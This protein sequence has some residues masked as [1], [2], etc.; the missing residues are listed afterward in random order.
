[1]VAGASIPID[2]N[3]DYKTP[4]EWL[5][6]QHNIRTGLELA[7][8][9]IPVFPCNED[10][11]PAT[12]HGFKDATT[13]HTRII[14]FFRPRNRVIGMPTGLASN[15]DVIDEDSHRGGDLRQAE[16]IQKKVVARTKSGGRHVFF[17][18]RDG[19]RNTTDLIP[20]IDVRGEGG[21]VILW[22]HSKDGEWFSG[23]LFSDLPEYPDHLRKGGVKLRAGGLDTEAIRNGVK[24]G[25]RNDSIFKGLCQYRHF[26]KPM[27]EAKKWAAE[28][29]MNS[30]PPY[31]EADTDEMAERVYAQ[32]QPG[33]FPE[34]D[35]RNRTLAGKDF[36][37]T[38]MGNAD[39]FE[40]LYGEN[41]YYVPD[42]RAF[43]VWTGKRWEI[44]RRGE[45]GRLAESTV[46][47]IYREAAD[48]ED[49]DKRK[50]VGKWAKSSEAHHRLQAMIER[51][52]NRRTASPDDFDRDSMLFNCANG[53]L[54]LRN[55]EL[56]DHSRADLITKLSPVAYD[57]N[58]K[59][60][61][62]NRTVSRALPG[63]AL[64]KFV[65][66][67]LGHSLTGDNSEHAL[68]IAHGGGANSKT[69]I[70]EG[71]MDCMGDYA[72]I[73]AEDVLI[74]KAG[75]H[76]TDVADLAG[77]RLV[78]A[79]EVKEGAKLDEPK[80][81][82]MTGD[83]TLKA[84]RMR[85]DFWEFPKTFK[86][87]M[88]VNHKPTIQ[89][90]DH[91]IWRRIKLIP[92]GVT[93][94]RAEQDPRLPEKL[95]DELPGILAW[96]VRGCLRWQREGLGEPAVVTAATNTYK[97][98]MDTLAAFLSDRCVIEAGAEEGATA[99]FNAYKAWCADA[100]E[101]AGTQKVFGGKLGERGFEKQRK[102][103]GM[104][105]FG[106]RLARPRLN[107]PEPMNHPEPKS[108]IDGLVSQSSGTNQKKVQDGSEGSAEEAKAVAESIRELY[109]E[110]D[111]HR[112]TDDRELHRTLLFRR[113]V[114]EVVTLATVKA[115][116]ETLP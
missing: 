105:Y 54:D 31:T 23:D 44:D 96:L 12:A 9:G 75:G 10:K 42:W 19:I 81:K 115:A 71:A 98:E 58:A 34:V 43:V 68:F 110:D 28:T 86:I 89:G 77:S 114:P 4:T 103:H 33:D 59:A 61:T 27:D 15:I 108:G 52:K 79:S 8:A 2:L 24:A 91:G 112:F 41:F 51:L 55:G 65:Q 6:S 73:S 83:R 16:P 13:N 36:H 3:N 82:R 62:W 93:I 29:A 56:R 74:D 109:E 116:R 60:P 111:T 11:T 67:A 84:R 66:R 70:L 100:N 57:P 48:T 102:E 25:A 104:V 88:P 49:T 85:E 32:Y 94:P 78:V 46:R 101:T 87:F 20:G 80:I 14:T 50:A 37:H 76:P 30:N 1:M 99:L 106:I 22:A 26:N 38:D 53:T 64:R 35:E 69:T 63:Y 7:D 45:M 95:R 90:T 92:F 113:L 47:A 97:D 17:K 107:V 39:R 18:H 40:H 72:T 5:G 21:Y